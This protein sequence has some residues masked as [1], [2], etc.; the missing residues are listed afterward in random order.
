[1][2]WGSIMKKLVLIFICSIVLLLN[3]TI[4]TFAYVTINDHVINGGVGDYGNARRNY[5]INSSAMNYSNIIDG[6]MN[7]WIYTTSRLGITTPISYRKTTSKANSVMDIY[8]GSYT[9][10]PYGYANGWTEFW[11]YQSEVI[12][13]HQNWGWNKV[14]LNIYNINKLNN[15]DS[16]KGVIAHEMGHCF[17][18]NE[19]NNNRYSIMCQMSEGRLVTESRPDDLH[20]INYLY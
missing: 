15:S 11:L 9:N 3:I 12:P 16:R 18:L 8:A 1:M 14:Y 19:N 4:Q 10:Y 5:Y 20:G 6:A 13:Y 2:G 7:D 17:G